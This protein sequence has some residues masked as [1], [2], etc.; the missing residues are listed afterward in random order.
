[1]TGLLWRKAA[2][3]QSENWKNRPEDMKRDLR[4]TAPIY[5]LLQTAIYKYFIDYLIVGD[6][7][8]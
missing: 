2:E 8:P 6:F 5:G 1:M 3:P 4:D 7:H